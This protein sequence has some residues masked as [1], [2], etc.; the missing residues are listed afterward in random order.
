M[1]AEGFVPC[2][3]KNCFFSI[4]SHTSGIKHAGEK[5]PTVVYR[6]GKRAQTIKCSTVRVNI[7]KGPTYC[8]MCFRKQRDE[9]TAGQ[10]K[11]KCRSSRLGCPI[12]E[13]HVCKSCW[14]SGYNLHNNQQLVYCPARVLFLHIHLP[15]LPQYNCNSIINHRCALDQAKRT[16]RG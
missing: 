8:N 12:C 5:R 11:K 16:A 14:D 7:G 4:N 9:D 1:R 13:E 6:C 3:C 15:I 2:N 10:R